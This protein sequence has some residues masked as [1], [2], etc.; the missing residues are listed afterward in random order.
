MFLLGI[1]I[2]IE[3]FQI[4]YFAVNSLIS[5]MFGQTLVRFRIFSFEGTIFKSEI[6]VP[7]FI[8]AD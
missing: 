7:P 2:G 1:L 3:I 4:F 8:K 6:K 5:K